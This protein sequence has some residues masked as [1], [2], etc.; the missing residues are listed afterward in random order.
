MAT[1]MPVAQKRLFG[2]VFICRDCNK[3]IRTQAVRIIA[4]KVRCPRCG[5]HNLRPVRKK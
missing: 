1:K 4:K 5:C 2:D 3:K